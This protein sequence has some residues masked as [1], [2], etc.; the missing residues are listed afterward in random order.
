MVFLQNAGIVLPFLKE[1]MPLFQLK[2]FA[3]ALWNRLDPYLNPGGER[4]KPEQQEECLLIKPVCWGSHRIEE[5]SAS[6]AS[7]FET[8][9]NESS[10]T[11]QR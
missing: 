5:H 1:T 9:I 2:S 7:S 8:S 4:R 11:S 6:K 10:P 3:K